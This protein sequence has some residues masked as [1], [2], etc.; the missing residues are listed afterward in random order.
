MLIEFKTGNF[1]SF[2]EPVTFSM[3]ATGIGE[4]ESTNTYEVDKMRLLKSAVIYGANASGKS[5]LIKALKFLLW[6]ILTS[7]KDMQATEKIKVSNFKLSSAT[8][9]KPSLFEIVFLK[10]GIKHRY[11]FEVDKNRVHKEWL[12]F[13]PKRQETK[14]FIRENDSVI[15]GSYFGEG[16]DL[17]S[18]TRPNALFLSVVAQFNGN[19][20]VSVLKWLK[21]KLRIISGLDD[22]KYANFTIQKAK[23]DE[24][25]KSEILKFLKIAD[26]GIK[27]VEVTETKFDLENVPKEVPEEIK[28]LLRS[29]GNLFNIAIKTGHQKY[30]DKNEPLSIEKFDLDNEESEGTKKFF[31][32]SGPLIDSLKNGYCLVIDELDSRMHPLLTQSII[33]IFNSELNTSNAQLIFVSHDTSLLNKD[34]FRRDQIWFIEKNRFGA[35]DMYSLVDYVTDKGKVR[36]DASYGKDYILGK[37]GAIP[38]IGDFRSLLG[39]Q[40]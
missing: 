11:G 25:Y 22:T 19:I 13:S 12:Y 6:F 9:N 34:M 3:L 4:H 36:N 17:M 30:N 14:L 1:L 38:Y 39:E 35:S 5:N 7:S 10:E 31:S 23:K 28:S 29:K 24:Y 27:N 33:K 18:K 2:N 15:L 8:D 16:K 37:Y 40:K 32:I 26:L 20:S 21:E